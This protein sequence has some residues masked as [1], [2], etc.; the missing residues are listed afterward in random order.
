MT[1]ELIEAGALRQFK[2]NDGSE[3]FVCAYDRAIV[4]RVFAAT[5][6]VVEGGSADLPNQPE[7]TNEK[8]TRAD[9]QGAAQNEGHDAGATGSSG[10]PRANQHHEHRGAEPGRDG[11]DGSEDGRGTGLPDR[12]EVR[13]PVKK[14]STHPV[15]KFAANRWRNP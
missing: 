3:G 11:C 15:E 8:Y 2:H 13:A 9:D 12:G 5:R 7:T 6:P 14:K 1:K 10:G 4:D